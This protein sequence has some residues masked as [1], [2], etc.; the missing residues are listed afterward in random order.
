MAHFAV[1][2]I[3][4][5]RHIV[6]VLQTAYRMQD[7][8]TTKQSWDGG[9]DFRARWRPDTAPPVQVAGQCKFVHEG[10]R[11]SPSVLHVRDFIGTMMRLHPADTLGLFV[12]NEAAGQNLLRT[13]QNVAIPLAVAQIQMERQLADRFFLNREA[14]RRWPW[15]CLKQRDQEIMLVFL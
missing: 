1:H 6:H 7:F 2:G 5:E 10:K 11:K 9:I 12:S 4:Y 13:V 14:A 8:S 15:I 3:S